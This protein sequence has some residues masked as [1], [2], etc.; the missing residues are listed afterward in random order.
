MNDKLDFNV[1]DFIFT[2]EKMASGNAISIHISDD[3]KNNRKWRRPQT[4]GIS[5]YI[6]AID[7]KAQHMLEEGSHPESVKLF[8]KHNIEQL[9]FSSSKK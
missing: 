6:K 8:I 7:K 4:N 2:I 5:G 3:N 1:D 9:L